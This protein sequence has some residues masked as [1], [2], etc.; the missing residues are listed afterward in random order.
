MQTVHRPGG[1]GAMLPNVEIQ[2][3][4]PTVY[5]L[6]T[7]VSVVSFGFF[8]KRVVVGS[9]VGF[10]AVQWLI[11][12]FTHLYTDYKPRNLSPEQIAHMKKQNLKLKEQLGPEGKYKKVNGK[13][14]NH[15]TSE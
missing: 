4:A 1:P 10:F 14:V 2:Q 9:T 5:A 11:Y 12:F 3:H 15:E 6:T 8:D 13:W 7:T